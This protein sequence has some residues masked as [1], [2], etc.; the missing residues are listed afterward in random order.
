MWKVRSKK[1]PS[2]VFTVRWEVW[3]R[4]YLG[5]KRFFVFKEAPRML[6]LASEFELVQTP[7]A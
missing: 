6:E 1:N 3:E 5:G 7:V 2:D 4:K